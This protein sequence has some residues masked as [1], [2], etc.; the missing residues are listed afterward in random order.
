M[1]IITLHQYMHIRAGVICYDDGCHLKRYAAK[2]ADLTE[3]SARINCC[4][5]VVD[6]MHFMGHTD[7]WCFEHCNP[8]QLQELENVNVKQ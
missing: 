4:Q 8:N 5:I 7:K 6:K 3:I 2:R 1:V